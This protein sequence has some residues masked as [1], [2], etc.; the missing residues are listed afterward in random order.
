MH[1]PD[2]TVA[3]N[4][5]PWQFSLGNLLFLVGAVSVLLAIARL[6]P[7]YFILLGTAQE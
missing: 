1:R 3:S 4:R 6:S 5:T 7:W 2:K